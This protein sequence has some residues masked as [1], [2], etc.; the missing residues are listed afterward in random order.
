MCSVPG[1]PRDNTEGLAT[2]DT[3]DADP[4]GFRSD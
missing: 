3:E 4:K 1:Q 2:D